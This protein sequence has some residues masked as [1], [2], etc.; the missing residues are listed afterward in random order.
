M[1][2]FR[3]IPALS[4]VFVSLFLSLCLQIP[5]ASYYEETFV[6]PSFWGMVSCQVLSTVLVFGLSIALSVVPMYGNFKRVFGFRKLRWRTV[7]IAAII[8]FVS[9]PLI[10]WGAYFNTQLID[11]IGVG[12][13]FDM[14]E[15]SNSM[16]ETLIDF[17]TPFNAV[18]TIVVV[19]L[20]PALLEEIFFRGL[21]Q[22]G[23]MRIINY[24]NSTIP[25]VMTAVLF[26]AVHGQFSMFVPRFLLGVILGA[27]F[28]RT[29]NLWVP[30]IVHWLNN[31]LVLVSVAMSDA[32]YSELNSQPIENPGPFLPIVSFI[33]VSVLLIFIRFTCMSKSLESMMAKIRSRLNIEDE[34]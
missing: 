15:K 2:P 5:L 13:V 19:S 17:S 4:I 23:M 12:E 27:L 6:N 18:T 16:V 22:K 28:V 34:D 24:S 8:L 26:S 25:V 29:A 21:V 33:S 9:I 30:I 3:P 20:L 32:S 11:M 10:N 7:V 31:A 1:K 14:D